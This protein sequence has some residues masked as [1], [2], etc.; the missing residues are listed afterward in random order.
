MESNAVRSARA[1]AKAARVERWRPQSWAKLPFLPAFLSFFFTAPF[2]LDEGPW[3]LPLPLSWVDDPLLPLEC[4][5]ALPLGLP[6]RRS[7]ARTAA[8]EVFSQENSLRP[9]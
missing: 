6:P 2:F 5:T 4:A 7:S 3:P 1:R 9:K 8:R